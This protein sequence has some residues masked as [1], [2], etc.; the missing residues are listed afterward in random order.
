MELKKALWGLSQVNGFGVQTLKSLAD[1]VGDLNDYF[2]RSDHSDL[3][4]LCGKKLFEDFQSR[5]ETDAFERAQEQ[6][7]GEGVEL[8]SLFDPDY[9]EFL[10][11]IYDPPMILYVKG[12]L[13]A[14]DKFSC[15]VVGTRHP[16]VYGTK[17]THHFA[18]GLAGFGL[19]VVSGLAKGIDGE[20]HRGALRA[21]GRTI[22]VL[23]SGLD[24]IYPREHRRLYEEILEQG[25]VISEYPFGTEPLPFN[26][27]RRNRIICGLS[28]GVLVVEASQR[29]GSLITSS[30]ALDEGRDVFA[31][32]GQLDRLTSRGTNNLVQKGAKLVTSPWD[33]LEDLAPQLKALS[34]NKEIPSETSFKTD[35]VKEDKDPLLQ[36]LS[37]KPLLFDE[38]L[39]R[40]DLEPGTL[41]A[42][43][44]DL[45]LLGAVERQF[46]GRY[47]K[48]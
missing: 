25:A 32:P 46:G 3:K 36:L 6:C 13:I 34:R 29:S 1:E 18:Q 20:A 43:L 39:G 38:L 2:K 16:S 14:E 47:S 8:L 42:R 15:A 11:A 40:T 37:E 19:T 21:G 28:M 24:I 35:N 48:A 22:A 17:M 26:F 44:I 5:L 27:P 7:R 45:E 4:C 41:Q 30:L 12:N 10:S 33:I 23:G 9:P 31:V